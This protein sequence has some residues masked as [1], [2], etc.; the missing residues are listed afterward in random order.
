MV[1]AA[2]TNACLRERYLALR[3]GAWIDVATTD[4]GQ[5]LGPLTVVTAPSAPLPG[6]VRTVSVSGGTLVEEFEVGEGRVIRKLSLVG[7]SSWIHITTKFEPA[8]RASL[9]QLADHFKFA[10]RADWA[11]SPSVGGFNPDAQYKVR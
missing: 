8:G 10:Q 5:T 1:E 9:R 3:D 11:F 2:V 4:P 7:N 6:A